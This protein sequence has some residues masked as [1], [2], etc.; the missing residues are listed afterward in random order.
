[1]KQ[2]LL[3]AWSV[4]KLPL[5]AVLVGFIVGAIC[6]LA[7]GSNPITAYAALFKGSLASI[8]S[9]GETLY[10]VTPILLTGLA[11]AIGFRCGLFNIGGE[12]QYVMAAISTVAAAWYFQW[13]PHFILV[14][15]L[16]VIGI[17]AGGTWGGIAG[18]LKAKMGINEVITTIM[19]N[20]T[21]LYLSN[22][23]V[24]T[25]LNPSN[26]L[27]DAPSGHTVV[28]PEV[29]RL[30]KLSSMVPA[31]G[32]S[33][34]HTGIF[35]ALGV[36][37][38]MWFILFKTT[39]GYEIRGVGLN[40]QAAEYGGIS[41]AKNTFLAMFIS[42]G[43]AGLAGSIQILGLVYMVNQS[44]EL[45][46]YGFTG[47]S[48][49]LVGLSHPLGCIPAAILFGILDNG[50][51]QMQL[52]GIPKEITAIIS[53]VIL[54]FVAGALLLKYASTRYEKRKMKKNGPVQSGP[55]MDT[56]GK[57]VE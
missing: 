28:V 54:V 9:I 5:I 47:L 2:R 23:L 50:S 36:A 7:A 1:M 37:V 6:I 46:G 27:G 57:G 38:L 45:P 32:F 53:A 49:A 22:Y 13:M 16:L 48:V 43:L 35:I 52:A 10:K 17:L 42:G 11:A 39:L 25:V 55:V 19:L 3:N 41:S 21:A 51:R 24:R 29:A 30:G 8:P 20:W 44:T 34:V 26:I 56:A 33:S 18:I 4:L 31:F 12:G 15:F 14:P 40:Y